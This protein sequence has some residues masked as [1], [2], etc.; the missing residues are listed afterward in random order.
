MPY[1]TVAQA[2]TAS[3]ASWST[4]SDAESQMT[5]SAGASMATN[6]DIFLSHAYEDAEVIAGM[7]LMIEKEDPHVLL[8]LPPSHRQQ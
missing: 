1:V 5:K 4:R 7:K 6:V 3:R 2:T 8:Q